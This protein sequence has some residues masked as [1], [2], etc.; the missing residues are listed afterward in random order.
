MLCC[1]KPVGHCVTV[2]GLDVLLRSNPSYRFNNIQPSNTKLLTIH[3]VY[4]TTCVTHSLDICIY[5]MITVSVVYLW[6]LG[7]V[8]ISVFSSPLSV[9]I[10]VLKC[11]YYPK[12]LA[13]IYIFC[14]HKLI[15]QEWL[16]F[17]LIRLLLKCRWKWQ[18]FITTLWL[19]MERV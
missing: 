15:I 18:T 6:I 9:F 5:L 3:S 2:I 4:N 11:F 17:F 8:C 16:M 13:Y 19:T 1:C 10:S 12:G 14:A 7:D